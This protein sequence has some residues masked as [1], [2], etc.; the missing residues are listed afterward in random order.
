MDGQQ[1][2]K[3]SVMGDI[4]KASHAAE[5][6]VQWAGMFKNFSK[7]AL[8]AFKDVSSIRGY[9]V[10][11]ATGT[12]EDKRLAAE[13]LY[14]RFGPEVDL[15]K[16]ERGMVYL[17]GVGSDDPVSEEQRGD[18]DYFNR[19]VIVPIMEEHNLKDVGEL[20]KINRLDSDSFWENFP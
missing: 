20:V 11:T 10:D 18:E 19:T 6:Q 12:E 17:S 16:L 3:P 7:D 13:Y 9:L 14:S 1:N 2:E 8:D 15:R 4:K 5:A